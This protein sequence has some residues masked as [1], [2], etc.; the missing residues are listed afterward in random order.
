[1][2]ISIE[3]DRNIVDKD[4]VFCLEGGRDCST[5]WFNSEQSCRVMIDTLG[6]IPNGKDTG[7][8]TK[9]GCSYS[10]LSEFYGK[11]PEFVC[12]AYKEKIRDEADKLITKS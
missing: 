9:C 3:I 2:P 12:K 1:M 7:L 4:N 5:V 11:Y 10:P 6:R 8:C